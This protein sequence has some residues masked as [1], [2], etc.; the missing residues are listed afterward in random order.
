MYISC[1]KISVR[2]EKTKP[3]YI[4]SRKNNAGK[5][6]RKTRRYNMTDI[7]VWISGNILWGIPMIAAMLLTGIFITIRLKA[8][9]VRKFGDSLSS[10]IIPTVRSIGKKSSGGDGKTKSISQFEAFSAAISGT[11]GTGNIVGVASALLS[12][13]PGA[14][15]WMW[16][17]A[18][19][20]LATNYSENVLGLYYRRKDKDGNIHGGPMYYIKYGLKLR[21]LAA[22]FA[23]FC[24]VAASGMGMVQANNITGTLQTTLGAGENK[25]KSGIIAVCVAVFVVFFTALI[26]IGGIKRIGK[27][28][29]MIVPFMAVLFIVMAVIIIS[30][31]ITAVPAAFAMIVKDAFSLRSFGGG[32]LG[33]GIMRAMRYGFAR[34]I[35]SNEAGLGSS[36]IAHSAS[37]TEEPVKQGLWGIFEVFIDTFVICTLTALTILTTCIKSGVSDITS[38]ESSYSGSAL[39]ISAFV[40]TLGNFGNAVFTVLMP[41]FA[42]TT[43]L[44]WSYYGEKSAQFLVPEKYQSRASN[45]FKFVYVMTLAVGALVKNDFVWA[46]DDMFNALMALPNLI[47]LILLSGTIKKIT[48]NYYQRKKGLN[49]EPMLSA[50]PEVNRELKERAEAKSKAENP[51]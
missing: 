4:N 39:S 18:F 26:V 16:V 28:A 37:E 36:V 2:T 12:G 49:V 43:I 13:G 45:I 21:W 35:F 38:L 41:L 8:I 14:V 34:G 1:L 5:T 42:F 27:V 24:M 17:S 40:G 10:T 6:D 33:Y 15:F 19:F 50:Y 20:G 29:S 48:E 31:N 3:G 22:A 44:A 7:I 32:L 9:Q 51:G 46:L 30:L 47:A 23:I 11:V 25:T